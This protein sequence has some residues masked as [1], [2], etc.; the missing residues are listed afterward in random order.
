[1][2]R[3]DSHS[4]Y[5]GNML[6]VMMEKRFRVVC[7]G[8]ATGFSHK[9]FAYDLQ[10]NWNTICHNWHYVHDAGGQHYVHLAGGRHY[11]H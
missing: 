4:F 5:K 11:I 2:D 6:A 1:M 8:I 10:W 3:I 7:I 9:R